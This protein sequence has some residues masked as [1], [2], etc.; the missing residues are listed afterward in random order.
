M[1]GTVGTLIRSEPSFP[2]RNES[3]ECE[4]GGEV[5]ERGRS[6]QEDWNF[7]SFCWLALKRQRRTTRRYPW[8]GRL[9]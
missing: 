8:L 2:R 5:T 9:G 3:K 1:T 6:V 7:S 4:L